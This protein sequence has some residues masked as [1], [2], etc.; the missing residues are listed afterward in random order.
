ME[1]AVEDF[2]ELHQKSGE[3]NEETFETYDTVQPKTRL[4]FEA[5]TC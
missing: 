3:D 2:M 1:V 5:D 4:G